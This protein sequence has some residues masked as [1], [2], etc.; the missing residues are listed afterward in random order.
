MSWSAG[1]FSRIHNWV[2]DRDAVI[3]ITASRMDE[4]SD[5][6]VAGINNTLT[7]DGQ[8][9]PTA[10]LP[11]ASQKHTT[12]GNA[13]ARNQYAAA[14]QVQDAAFIYA[15]DSG[16]AD[17]YAITL[18]PAITAY[19]TGALYLFKA[20]N[21]NTG[22]STLNVNGL[23][24]KAIQ[25]RG[26]AL[27]AGDIAANNLVA[28]V[29]DGTQ[30]Q[31]VSPI[32]TA[33]TPSPITTRGDVIRG[34]SAG[35]EERLALGSAGQA[36]RSDGTD[37]V[38]G[39]S[40]VQAVQTTS[41]V[42]ATGTTQVPDDNTIPQITEGTEFFTL[43]I[44]PKNASS[45]LIIT[46]TVNWAFSNGGRQVLALF[47]DSTANAL[48]VASD[49]PADN[50]I[51]QHTTLVHRMTAGTTSATTF[52]LRI[53]NSNSGTTTVNGYSGSQRYGGRLASGMHI[54]EVSP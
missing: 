12:V 28:V 37:L 30:F 16:A 15:A 31:L 33:V 27:A 49:R 23:G 11:M 26:A 46:C 4:D 47:Q 36:V 39:S 52:R 5:D 6:F 34:S 32:V 35:A 29:Y 48:A 3:N 51:I 42:V 43:A 1:I 7:K 2:S 44:T 53:G 22:A 54:L 13:S 50:D 8:N 10:D 24:A 45:I 40:L 18:A 14:G 25:K 41:G 17:V 20:A 38:F 19:A 9:S 21:T